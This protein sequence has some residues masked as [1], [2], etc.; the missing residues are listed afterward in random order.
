M[1]TLSSLYLG[2]EPTQ[3]KVDDDQLLVILADGHTI[4]IP[5]QLVGQLGQAVPLPAEAQWK[6]KAR[7]DAGY[8]RDSRKPGHK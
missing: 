4:A 5:L 6:A 3:V 8:Y 1:N 7:Y 2:S